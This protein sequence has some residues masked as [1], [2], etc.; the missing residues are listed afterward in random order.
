MFAIL[1]V[2]GTCLHAAYLLHK[3]GPTAGMVA[4]ELTLTNLADGDH[5]TVDFGDF[6]KGY[7]GEWNSHDYNTNV[8]QEVDITVYHEGNVDS[9]MVAYFFR[10]QSGKRMS[11]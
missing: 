1:G 3:P 11:R 6:Y 7:K 5:G 10:P 2:M 9:T 4:A 8:I